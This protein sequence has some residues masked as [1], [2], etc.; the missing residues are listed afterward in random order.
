[1]H[2]GNLNLEAPILVFTLL[3][4]ALI[5]EKYSSL[6]NIGKNHTNSC[7]FEDTNKSHHI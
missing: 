4:Y 2:A 1:M 3:R 6:A 7:N 5:G